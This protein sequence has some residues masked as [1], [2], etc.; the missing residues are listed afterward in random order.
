M[1][2]TQPQVQTKPIDDKG[3]SKQDIK[4][5]RSG[6]GSSADLPQCLCLSGMYNLRMQ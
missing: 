2:Y 5:T 1:H 6:W 4:K 3:C